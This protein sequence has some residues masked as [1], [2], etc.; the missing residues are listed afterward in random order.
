MSQYITLN[1]P[2]LVNICIISVNVFVI[3]RL[4]INLLEASGVLYLI[5]LPLEKLSYTK[6]LLK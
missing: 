6:S 1:T 4:H 3:R 2:F 5:V